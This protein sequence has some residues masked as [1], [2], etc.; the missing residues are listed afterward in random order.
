MRRLTGFLSIVL[1]ISAVVMRWLSHQAAE[2]SNTA[3]AQAGFEF[4]SGLSQTAAVMGLVTAVG[5]AFLYVTRRRR[6]R[7]FDVLPPASGGN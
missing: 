7:G 6:E 2:F 3:K 5:W 4:W 1:L